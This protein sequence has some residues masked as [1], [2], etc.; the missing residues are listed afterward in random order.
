[1]GPRLGSFG[2]NQDINLRP[3]VRVLAVAWECHITIA[4]MLSVSRMESSWPFNRTVRVHQLKLFTRLKNQR[5][6]IGHV[7]NQDLIKLTV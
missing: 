6:R 3:T 5:N 2:T 1:M 4:T 7:L